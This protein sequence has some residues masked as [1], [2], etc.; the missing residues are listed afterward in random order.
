MDTEAE[1]EKEEEQGR[2]EK[3]KRGGKKQG[4]GE[5]KDVNAAFEK[6]HTCQSHLH[7]RAFQLWALLLAHGDASY[8]LQKIT[9]LGHQLQ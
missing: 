4:R 8:Q 2:R 5:E 1:V 6:M 9:Q 3:R 7:E